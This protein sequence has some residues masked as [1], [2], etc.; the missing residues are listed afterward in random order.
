M[1]LQKASTKN[2]KGDHSLRFA[3]CVGDTA[4]TILL[5]RNNGLTLKDERLKCTFQWSVVAQNKNS[6]TA[7]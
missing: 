2:N 4:G 6:A 1:V 3:G 5:I 7:F